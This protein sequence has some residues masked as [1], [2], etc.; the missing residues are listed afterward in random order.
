M[1]EAAS[2]VG[3]RSRFLQR[4]PEDT[5]RPRAVRNLAFHGLGGL[6]LLANKLRHELRGYRTPRPFPVTMTAQ[7][8]S[9]DI[10]VVSGWLDALAAYTDDAVSVEDRVVLELGP[11][12]DL[13]AGLLLLQRGARAYH[14][15]DINDLARGAPHEF[16]EQLLARLDNCSRPGREQSWLLH[17]LDRTL[18]GSNDRL[19]Y[20]YDPRFDVRRFAGQNVDLV[21]SQ[22]AFEHFDDPDNTI[23]QLSEVVRPGAILISEIDLQTHSRWLRDED[24]LNIYRFSD[25][26]YRWLR[27]LG[28]PNRTRPREYRESLVKHGW[29]NVVMLPGTLLEDSYLARVLPSLNSRFRAHGNEMAVLNLVVCATRA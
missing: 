14:A 4:R 22:A 2:F 15:L 27:F 25:S 28:S 8:A 16:Y 3:D 1:N 6:M 11:G 24:P 13:G 20:V 7:A 10:D 17:Q 12:P 29:E 5:V 9:Y 18:A 26:V 21:F 19:N 23:A